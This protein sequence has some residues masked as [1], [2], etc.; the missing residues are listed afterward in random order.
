MA[1]KLLNP[2]SSTFELVRQ[3]SKEIG[4]F[5]LLFSAIS[6]SQHSQPSN[7]PLQIKSSPT[8]LSHRYH[9]NRRMNNGG[10]VVKSGRW[11]GGLRVLTYV[12]PYALGLLVYSL[13]MGDL[14]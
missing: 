13:M 6:P 2:K 10:V 12:P 4:Y 14:N 3:V 9:L 5:K 8:R 11:V 7:I 1:K